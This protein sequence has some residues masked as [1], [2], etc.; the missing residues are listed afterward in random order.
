M[1]TERAE[2][3][4]QIEAVK[5]EIA[6]LDAKIGLET[7]AR[8]IADLQ[9]RKAAR[10]AQ[11]ETWRTQFAQLGTVVEGSSVNSSEHRRARHAR[12]ARW[13]PTWA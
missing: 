1:A 11:L 2:L 12:L 9:S 4:L 8:A 13:G 10:Q 3:R 7:S 6:E 5:T